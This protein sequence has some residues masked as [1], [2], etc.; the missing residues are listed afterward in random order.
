M[1]LNKQK[2]SPRPK[3]H[4]GKELHYLQIQ[5]RILGEGEKKENIDNIITV[6]LATLSNMLENTGGF[7]NFYGKALQKGS[8][9]KLKYKYQ[10]NSFYL[11]TVKL[12][13][14]NPLPSQAQT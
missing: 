13:G 2:K 11:V 4:P 14:K 7:L 6:L 12:L 5:E 8:G 1:F 10:Q 3:R 9:K